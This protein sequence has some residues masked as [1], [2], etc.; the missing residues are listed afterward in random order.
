VE[1]PAG[2]R[3]GPTEPRLLDTDQ[4]LREEDV[5]PD[6]VVEFG[7]WFGLAGEAGE[8]QPNAMALATIDRTGQPTVRMV[9]LHRADGRGFTFYTNYESA[10]ARDLAAN[11]RAALAFYWPLLHRQVRVT[12][13]TT[14]VGRA[15][16]EEYWA[17]RPYG[18]RISASASAQSTVIADRVALDAEVARLEAL[19]PQAPP[20]PS[21][22]G[23]YR[24][25]P[26]SVELWQGRSHR[27][28][29]R[30]LYSRVGAAWRLERLAP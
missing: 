15:E 22:W 16:S 11:P 30:L 8:P 4:P 6:P 5:D 3:T 14:K 1:R 12:G 13:L 10:K 18:S 17:A 19:Y 9:L 23:G 25:V 20:L 26:K 29:D 7:R 24:L 27:L 2:G 21:F 28:H